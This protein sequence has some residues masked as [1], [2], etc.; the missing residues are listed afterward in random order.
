MCGAAAPFCSLGTCIAAGAFPIPF[1]PESTA[2][3]QVLAGTDDSTTGL[4]SMGMNFRF[5][6]VTYSQINI[7]SNG[8]IGFEGG[9][10][11]GCCSGQPIPQ[12][13]GINNIIAAAWNDIYPAGGGEI[14]YELRGTAP[15]RRFVVSYT[16]LPFYRN[17]GPNELTS[18]IILYEGSNRIEIHTS[19]L[20]VRGNPTTQG[21][22]N[23]SGS[24]AYFLPGRSAAPFGLDNDGVLFLTN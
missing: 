14:R 11:Q 23:A 13:E 5:F 12:D 19:H 8:F 15:N 18:Q 9:M 17:F 1:A 16:N 3:T 6:G 24:T 7:S 10:S 21:V 20:S 22:E 4:F 2:G